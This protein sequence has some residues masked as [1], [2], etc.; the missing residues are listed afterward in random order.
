MLLAERYL[1]IRYFW[2]IFHMRGELLSSSVILR[3]FYMNK[4][5]WLIVIF[6]FL[7]SCAEF[8][9]NCRHFFNRIALP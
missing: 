1:S 5:F 9:R 7:F 6:R 2:E 3:K 8:S 4:P